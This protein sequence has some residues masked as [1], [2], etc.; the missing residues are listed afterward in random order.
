M[1]LNKAVLLNRAFVF[2]GRGRGLA[3]G[4]QIPPASMY[5]FDSL[6]IEIQKNWECDLIYS[7]ERLR[8]PT[9]LLLSVVAKVLSVRF[10]CFCF[11]N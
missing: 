5:L 1:Q 7:E 4:L 9:Y 2:G 11:T 3:L 6:N 10:H 8:T